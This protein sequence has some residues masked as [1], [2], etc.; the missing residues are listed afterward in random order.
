MLVEVWRELRFGWLFIGPSSVE[1]WRL[2]GGSVG[3]S[4]GRFN[5]SVTQWRGAGRRGNEGRTIAIR[6]R[7]GGSELVTTVTLHDV[8]ARSRLVWM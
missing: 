3:G 6:G 5:V 1:M 2:R 8:V 7:R 4:G